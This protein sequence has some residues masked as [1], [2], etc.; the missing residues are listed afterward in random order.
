VQSL[1]PRATS[2][3]G[4]AALSK[5]RL[6]SISLDHTVRLWD[7]RSGRLLSKLELDAPLRSFS[8]DAE[9]NMIIVGDDAGQLHWISISG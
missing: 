9:E 1:T 6:I 3:S 8:A 7:L 2:V 5:D 4:F